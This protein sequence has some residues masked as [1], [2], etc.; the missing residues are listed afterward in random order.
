M[1]ARQSA[2]TAGKFPLSFNPAEKPPPANPQPLSTAASSGSSPQSG[3]PSPR[4]LDQFRAICRVKHYSLRTEESYAG[5]ILR[6]LRF[7]DKRHPRELGASHIAAFLSH[8]AVDLE[9]APASQNQ[10]LNAI[11]FLYKQVLRIDPGSFEDFTRA[12]TRRHLPVI[13]TRPETNTLIDA[14]PPP[15]RLMALLLYGAGLRLME[16]HRLR[17]KDIDFGYR[18]IC[19]RDGKGAKDRLTILPD[20]AIDALKQQLCGSRSLFELDRRN[21]T[22]GV[23][24]P[25][26]LAHKYPNASTDW[27]WFWLFPAPGLSVDPRSRTVRRHHLHESLLQRAVKEAVRKAGIQK[28]ATPHTLRHCFATHLLESGSDIRTVQELLGHKDVS[29]TMIY[30]HVV[31]RPGMSVRSPADTS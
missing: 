6:F 5:W 3:A 10:A 14:L 30:T 17:I 23:H 12:K 7:H 29:T 22:P 15:C 13:L 4:L 21:A 19:V 26:A 20:A 27:R 24:L 25:Y 28:P 16:C 9:V 31:N 11:V 8:L 1:K 2:E 18:Q